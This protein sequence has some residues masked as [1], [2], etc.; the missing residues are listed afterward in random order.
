MRNVRIAGGKYRFAPGTKPELTMEAELERL[1]SVCPVDA[2]IL[3]VTLNGE[4]NGVE[5]TWSYASLEDIPDF[6]L[7]I[8]DIPGLHRC[9]EDCEKQCELDL[10]TN[11]RVYESA[12]KLGYTHFVQ[13]SQW[14]V[15]RGEID[16][17]GNRTDYAMVSGSVGSAGIYGQGGAQ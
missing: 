11:A 7:D 12:A 9:R 5:S 10:A 17:V 2:K 6:P 1:R 13:D 15:I 4:A 8:M 14:G 16:P 3:F